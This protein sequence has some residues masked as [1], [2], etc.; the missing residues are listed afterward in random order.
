VAI[1]A[2]APERQFASNNRAA[3][4]AASPEFIG[5]CPKEP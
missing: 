2:S 3:E 5:S 1:D 4:F